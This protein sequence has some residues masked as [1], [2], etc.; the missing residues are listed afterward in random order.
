MLSCPRLPMSSSS[1][2]VLARPPLTS[3]PCIHQPPAL[4]GALTTACWPWTCAIG[5]APQASTCANS[6]LSSAI[7]STLSCP[8]HP[9][10]PSPLFLR[11]DH[12]LLTDCQCHIPHPL[13]SF[14]RIHIHHFLSLSRPL[15]PLLWALSLLLV[16]HPVAFCAVNSPHLIAISIC[17]HSPSIFVFPSCREHWTSVIPHSL[18]LLLSLHWSANTCT[19]LGPLPP[20]LYHVPSTRSSNFFRVKYVQLKQL[21]Y[22]FYHMSV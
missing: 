4:A 16:H 1:A 9:L 6:P 19:P 15:L 12:Y 17:C 2:I 14:H 5:T 7:V 10:S 13:S 18:S 3:L 21:Y 11:H 8:C 22:V 20:S